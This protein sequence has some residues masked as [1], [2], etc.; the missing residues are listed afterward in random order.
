[1]NIK[2]YLIGFPILLP[3]S[4]FPSQRDLR[5]TAGNYMLHVH[6]LKSKWYKVGVWLNH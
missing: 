3:F 2:S 1:M 5:F 4:V 6:L